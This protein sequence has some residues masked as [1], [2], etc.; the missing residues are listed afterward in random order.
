MKTILRISLVLVAILFAR[1]VRSGDEARCHAHDGLP[2]AACTPGDVEDID[3][4]TLCTQ[5]T[6][7]RRAVSEATKRAV[8]AE[9]GIATPAPHGAYEVD[10]LVSLELGGSNDIA[11]LWPEAAEP[12]PGFHEKDQV[13]NELHRQVCAGTMTL[14]DAQ[15]IIA[16]DWAQVWSVMQAK[17][18]VHRA[19]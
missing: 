4:K 13:E 14:G 10:H 18:S 11:N 8:F 19:E 17:R 9:Y 7:E 15:H 1:D 5:S 12:R 3:T 16:T 6:K 2:D